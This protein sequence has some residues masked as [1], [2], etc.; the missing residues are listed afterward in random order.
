MNDARA[1]I[2]GSGPGGATAADV[3]T[4]AGWDVVILEKGRNHLIDLEAPYEPKGEFS[5]DELKFG[6]RHFLG[7]DPLAEP[8]TFRRG[9]ADGD[10]I[11][12]GDVN[13]L[14]STVGGGGPHADGKLPRFREDDFHVRSAFGPIEGAAVEDWPLTYDELE[15]YYAEV[16]RL[17]GVAGAA[18][19]NPFAAWRS[20]PYPMPPGPDMYGATLTAPAAEKLGLHPYRAPTGANSEP[21]DGRPACNNC[22][23]CGFYGCPI[24]AK[25]DPIAS[26]RRALLTGRCEI[27]PEAYV[28]EVVLDGSGR[29][30][31]GVRYLDAGRRVQEV[32]AEHVVL[33][34]GAFETPRLLLR[35]GLANSSG[36]VGRFLTVH[37]QTFVVGGFPFDLLGD[38]GRAVTHL[39]DDFIVPGPDDVAAAREAGLP[40]MKGG[41][42]EHGSAA[43]PIQEAVEYPPGE[44]H[45][46]AMRESALR[47]KL[48]VFT[49]QGEDLPQATN[50]I[51]LDP[52]VVDAWGFP[53][54]RLTYSPHRHELVASAHFAP[55]LEAVLREAGA[56]WTI[57]TTSPPAPDAAFDTPL[58]V[59]PA[60]RH[61]MGTCR[62]GADPATSV[63]D[64]EGRFWD[65]ENMVCADSSV[66]VTAAGYNPTLTLTALAHRTASKLAGIGPP[67]G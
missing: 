32:R 5:N 33:A 45:T 38:R 41:V 36:L 2:V 11:H 1:V 26:L 30:A 66:F 51:D 54:G 61:I 29:R 35:N 25:G 12:V 46:A 8:R 14:P 17:I 52:A 27:R 28:T 37:F 10:R 22:G 20:G 13:N 47:R 42:V 56:E 59:A 9:E 40:W 24:H 60:S 4:A 62:M 39:H 64:P 15:P 49:M 44:L 16:E 18:E 34:C 63:V 23:F 31:T 53:A 57:A 43:G 7:P 65:V 55:K 3:L 50:R 19:A 58:G 6:F 48:W 21:Y 67:G